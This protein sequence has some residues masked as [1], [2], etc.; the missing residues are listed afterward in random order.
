MSS[1]YD[2]TASS[3]ASHDDM[4][5]TQESDWN[6]LQ[7]SLAGTEGFIS[8]S[9]N[10]TNMENAL[11]HLPPPLLS[12]SPS[13]EYSPNTLMSTA[14]TRPDDYDHLE[15]YMPWLISSATPQAASGP[16]GH[17]VVRSDEADGDGYHTQFGEMLAGFDIGGQNPQGVTVDNQV[18]FILDA[19]AAQHPG[20]PHNHAS[21]SSQPAF[22]SSGSSFH[23]L[24]LSY[25]SPPNPSHP[26]RAVFDSSRPFPPFV[27]RPPS[28]PIAMTTVAP[29]DVF[30]VEPS[31][32]VED[33]LPATQ[34]IAGPS[35]LPEARQQ[36]KRA[37]KRKHKDQENAPIAQ[38]ST[39]RPK[40]RKLASSAPL[41]PSP[42]V[43]SAPS[44]HRRT[45]AELERVIIPGK[46]TRCGLEGCGVKLHSQAE[47][48]AHARTHYPDAPK[49]GSG[50]SKAK[51]K[52]GDASARAAADVETVQAD[53]MSAKSPSPSETESSEGTSADEKK[54]V[55]CT[56][57]HEGHPG[58]RCGKRFS[59]V[60]SLSRHV[61]STHYG[62]AFTCPKCGG[63][64]SRRYVL[65]RHIDGCRGTRQTPPGE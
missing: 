50:N 9:P 33:V 8:S 34:P 3:S 36:P 44:R 55:V 12:Q 5:G 43:D 26:P 37:A 56:H 29:R 24:P 59:T 13:F 60:L 35:R 39:A 61:E 57:E 64:Y 42:S 1:P 14:A 20:S 11:C 6:G 52:E 22:P 28:P 63:S 45:K 23:S 40:R 31:C 18:S 30:G 47:A 65:Q 51:A 19:P 2:S 58:K 17:H 10:T 54:P 16:S 38:A 7:A 49:Q 21:T 4:H 62:W 27:L 46:H 32:P 25:A 41:A 15:W 48:R 53:A